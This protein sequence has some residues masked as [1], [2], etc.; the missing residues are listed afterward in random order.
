[1]TRGNHSEQRICWR[2]TLGKSKESAVNNNLNARSNQYD[3]FWLKNEHFYLKTEDKN[4][5]L[6]SDA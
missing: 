2:K 6:S 4:I 1:M 3:G 5:L